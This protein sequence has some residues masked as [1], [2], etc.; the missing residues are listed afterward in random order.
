MILKI[1]CSP[2]A[3]ISAEESKV[4]GASGVKPHEAQKKNAKIESQIMM[5]DSGTVL[6]ICS[7][8]ALQ[9]KKKTVFAHIYHDYKEPG[10][11]V[12]NEVVL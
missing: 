3:S 5:I 7:G 4:S 1:Y 9:M 11:S 12:G 2:S 6:N 10:M 8:F